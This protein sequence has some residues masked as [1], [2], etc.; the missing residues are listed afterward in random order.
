MLANQGDNTEEMKYT[1]CQILQS[2]IYVVGTWVSLIRWSEGRQIC[3]KF[4]KIFLDKYTQWIV[5]ECEL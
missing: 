4:F 1:P 3:N 5:I 2:A